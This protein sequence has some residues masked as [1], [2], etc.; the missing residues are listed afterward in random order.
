ME[1]TALILAAGNGK[2][3]KSKMLKIMHPILGKPMVSYVIDSVK[4][5]GISDI[6]L[7]TCRDVD[8]IKQCVGEGYGYV[9][10]HE[11]KG[12]GDAV[13]SARDHYKGRKGYM[14]VLCGDTPLIK[15]TTIKKMIDKADSAKPS[16]VM[17]TAKVPDP[18][19]YGRVI[20]DNTGNIC[21]IVEEVDAKIEER[22]INEINTGVYMFNLEDVWTALEQVKPHNNQNEF[23]LTDVIS[24][25]YNEGKTIVSE[26]VEDVTEYHG[27]N[28]RWDL[29]EIAGQMQHE[30]LKKHALNGVTIIDPS[31]T[32]IEATVKIAHDVTIFP[33]VYLQ[34]DITI[35]EDCQIGPFVFLKGEDKG[36][37]ISKNVQVGPFV[38]MRPPID[39]DE[40]AKIGC[41][42]DMKKVK[43]GK[44]SKIP[45]LAYVGDTEM[46]EDVNIGAGT[47]TCNYDG[48]N[49]NKTK[50][51]DRVFIGSDTMLIAPIEIGNDAYTGA[52]SVI[53]RNVPEG[54]LAIERSPMNIVEGWAKRKKLGNSKKEKHG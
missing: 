53:N 33:Y 11:P 24:I 41:F 12:T 40:N 3:M 19:G 17:L 2:R 7:V 26:T 29:T 34:G 35:D 50:I 14:L 44:G 39:I 46:G 43:M 13:N 1:A 45:H 30:I 38:R 32:Y 4:N 20:R 49:K 8:L 36:I 9:T 37:R 5:A 51:G 48:V 42:I 22:M 21:N 25:L 6:T 52:G 18:T 54:S 10:Q 28:N 27:I 16:C 23:Y 31:S 47:I 15:T